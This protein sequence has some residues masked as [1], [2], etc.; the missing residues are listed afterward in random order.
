MVA[1]ETAGELVYLGSD[2]ESE[3]SWS[4]YV[5][6]AEIS[7]LLDAPGGPE[8]EE[9]CEYLAGDFARRWLALPGRGEIENQEASM[10]EFDSAFCERISQFLAK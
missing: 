7:D 2:S 10:A 6:W 9:L 4:A 5:I 1:L 8:S 3:S